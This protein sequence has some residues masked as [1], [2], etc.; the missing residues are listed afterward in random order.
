MIFNRIHVDGFGIWRDLDLDELDPGLNVLLAPNE[1]GKTTLMSFIRSALFGFRRRNDPQ[2]YEPLRGGKHGG[3]IDFE[4]EGSRYR[5]ARSADG[6]SSGSIQISGNDGSSLPESKLAELLRN[7]TDVLFENVFAFGLTELQ[8]L[9]TLQKD[10]VAGH[11]YSAGMASGGQDPIG[12]RQ[13]LR[14]ERDRLYLPRG[15]KQAVAEKLLEINLLQKEID[16]LQQLPEEHANLLQQG[17]S[18]GERLAEVDLI[19]ATRQSQ[20]D[21]ARRAQ[22]AWRDYEDL[23]AAESALKALGVPLA[24]AGGEMADTGSVGRGSG[25]KP[26]TPPGARPNT[27]TSDPAEL[28]PPSQR[29]LLRE[30]GRIRTLLAAAPRLREL[31]ATIQKGLADADT[32]QAALQT[33]LKDLGKGWDAER[34]RATAT[35][36]KEREKIRQFA[37]DIRQVESEIESISSRAADAHDAYETIVTRRDPVSREAVMLTWAMVAAFTFISAVVVPLVARLVTTSAVGAIGAMTGIIMT[38]LRHRGRQQMRDERLGAADRETTLWAQ[39]EDGQ[40]SLR[41]IEDKWQAWLQG[42]GLDTDLGTD[43]ALDLLDRIREAQEQDRRHEESA[44]HSEKATSELTVACGRVNALFESLHRDQISLRAGLQEA[45]EPLLGELEALQA[46]LESA[47][48]QGM[49]LRTVVDQ[50]AQARAA[51]RA[52]AGEEGPGALRARLESLDPDQIERQVQD[53]EMDVAAASAQRDGLNEQLGGVRERLTHL[54]GDAELSDL[55]QARE[56]K[57]SE[58]AG[59]LEKWAGHT[60]AGVL[61]DLAKQ[62]YEEQRQPEVLKLASRY[63]E[64]MTGGR[65]SR[66]L[67]PLGETRLEVEEKKGGRRKGPE[68]LSRGTSEQLYLAMRL[69][70]AA[71]YANQAVPLPLVTDD[72][73]VNFDDARA[74]STATLLGDFAAEGHQVLAFTCHSHLADVFTSQVPGAKLIP[75]PRPV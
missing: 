75:L 45:V 62:V 6:T 35:G 64:T 63:F 1:G 38:W 46:E 17:R 21:A 27:E 56:Q 39:H 32:A 23:L 60:V 66:V 43:G 50:Y 10:E 15:R 20:L 57:R 74:A 58:L 55:L 67:A 73:L 7:T 41:E 24:A 14:K 22:R 33:H 40:K 31:R 51:L 34:I 19:I 37:E 49:R 52:V 30:S 28:L 61:F 72:I 42:Q 54:E 2:R 65:Y 3:H 25:E 16:P 36:L 48:D 59:L 47:E 70:L 18:L 4:A 13:W 69:A 44:T 53:A 9:D 8:R 26:V 11:I 29:S 12:F 5:V 71:V 68:A